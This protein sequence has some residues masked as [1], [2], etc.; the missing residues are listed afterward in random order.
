MTYK[1]S[2][3]YGL[4]LGFN[5]SNYEAL[6]NVDINDNI[7]KMLTGSWNRTTGEVRLYVNGIL[8]SSINTGQTSAIALADGL[9]TVGAEYHSLGNNGFGGNIYNAQ[10]YNRVLS[11][12]EVAQNFQA[13]RG[14]YGI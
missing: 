4:W 13:Y 3:R 1:N 14:R 6:I 11:D 9:I 5:T 12:T 2:S 8:T 10:I 7:N